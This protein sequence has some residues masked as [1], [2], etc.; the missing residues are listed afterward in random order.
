MSRIVSELKNQVEELQDRKVPSTPPKVL[1]EWSRAGSEAFGNIGEG[2]KIW[3]KV[4]ESISMIWES[5]L[6]DDTGEKI[7]E[8]A[9]QAD[10]KIT[11]TN[12]KM[13][14]L[15]LKE[16]VT[17]IVEIKQLQQEVQA[18]HDQEWTR[19]EEVVAYQLET[20]WVIGLIQPIQ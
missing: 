3:T 6:E 8:N 16:K 14:K 5:L 12:P 17:N 11:M 7:K 2:D 4:V 9:W 13:K 18:L 15:P 10:N 19:N 20:S 1:E